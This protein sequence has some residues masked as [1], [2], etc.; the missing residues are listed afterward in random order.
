MSN[1]AIINL[2]RSVSNSLNRLWWPLRTG[3]VGQVARLMWDLADRLQESDAGLR[4]VQRRATEL[5]VP[6]YEAAQK[7]A[8][9]LA[10]SDA[11][12]LVITKL[13]ADLAAERERC[14]RLILQ[15]KR[16]EKK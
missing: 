11:R 1:A 13:T 2:A 16:K 4:A 8:G 9:L 6:Q 15:Q 10:L 7:H 3:R 5:A 12:A 14:A